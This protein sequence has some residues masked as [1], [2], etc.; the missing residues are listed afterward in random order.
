MGKHTVL[1][2]SYNN[3]VCTY[4]LSICY[5]V[6]TSLSMLIARKEVCTKWKKVLGVPGTLQVQVELLS[7]GVCASVSGAVI[8]LCACPTVSEAVVIL[9]MCVKRNFRGPYISRI[10]IKFI[11][12]ETNFVDCM[13]KA[14]PTQ[15]LVSWL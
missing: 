7:S 1:I 15:V 8:I 9:C 13:I 2:R 14:T 5:V 11:F 10:A 4:N 3:Y 6:M 12:A